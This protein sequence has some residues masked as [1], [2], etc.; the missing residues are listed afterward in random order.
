MKFECL[1]KLL[2]SLISY[3]QFS[4]AS[5]FYHEL[6]SF[7]WDKSITSD[8][9]PNLASIFNK[10]SSYHFE[11][12][13]YHDSMEAVVKLLATNIPPKLSIDVLR[14]ASKYCVVKR[15]FVKA[16][17]LVKQA[18]CLAKEVYGTSHSKYVDC[19]ND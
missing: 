2:H 10:Y 8:V 5:T 7:T 3:S 4:E 11:K 6:H 1:S 9:Y 15:E 19:L 13:N 17:L 16:E 18:V 14:Q 12:S